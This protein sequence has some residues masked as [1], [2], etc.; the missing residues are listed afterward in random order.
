M[1]LLNIFKITHY[2]QER[3]KTPKYPRLLIPVYEHRVEAM[4]QSGPSNSLE[5]YEYGEGDHE[6]VR[7]VKHSMYSWLSGGYVVIMYF[8]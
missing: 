2:V 1:R 7:P 5:I 6:T 8:R 4:K 3:R